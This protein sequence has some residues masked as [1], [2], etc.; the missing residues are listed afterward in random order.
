MAVVW[1]EQI[2][3]SLARRRA[4]IV[5]G[6][7]VSAN[8]RTEAGVAP[9]I[10]SS[11]L[12]EAYT[13][14]GRRV[15]HI[16]RALTRY[17][18]LAACDYLKTEHG[19]GWAPLLRASFAAPRYL[20]AEI[21]ETIFNLDSR[22]VASLNFDKIYE[23]Y[24]IAASDGTVVVKN[25][26]DQD[27][28][29]V[30]AGSGRYIIKPHGDIDTVPQLIFTHSEYTAA[31]VNHANFYEMMGALLHTH[32]FIMIGCG[33]SDPDIQIMFEDYLHKFQESAHFMTY[34]P[35]MSEAEISLV[36][37]TRGIHLLPY[38]SK[39]DHDELKMSLKH[40]VE[41]VGERR[42]TLATDFNW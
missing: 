6:S 14:L 37:R 15:S 28:R 2:I 25:Y 32:T 27:I 9:P 29:Q 5:I 7:G 17:D 39:N 12:K 30:L 22:I 40:L 41:L 1:P 16:Q 3:D 33:L 11:F 31:R 18:Y 4:V 36:E 13:R 26:Y 42:Q 34:S 24:A 8:A 35:K 20:P 21:H 19:A 38:S 10:W 23:T